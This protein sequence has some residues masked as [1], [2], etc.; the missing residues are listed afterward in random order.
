MN[1]IEIATSTPKSSVRHIEHAA[2][3]ASSSLSHD[4][5]NIPASAS[6]STSTPSNKSPLR[7]HFL[8]S[9]LSQ[10]LLYL[11]YQGVNER[12]SISQGYKLLTTPSL[13]HARSLILARQTLG[14]EDSIHLQTLLYTSSRDKVRRSCSQPP[15]R[16]DLRQILSEFRRCF[17]A[18]RST[19]LSGQNSCMSAMSPAASSFALYLSSRQPLYQLSRTRTCAGSMS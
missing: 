2:T 3:S 5:W 15:L 6:S 17:V 7:T 8:F 9:R 13:S 14:S 12:A 19:I 18:S 16:A 11:I 4:S 1:M 10:I